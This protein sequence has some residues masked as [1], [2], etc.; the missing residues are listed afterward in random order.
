M[1]K[2]EL[3]CE[4]FARE[5]WEER[6]Y[7]FEKSPNMAKADFEN[8][9]KICVGWCDEIPEEDF[10]IT[11]TYMCKDRVVYVFVRERID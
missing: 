7:R 1:L 10:E 3:K 11:F 6:E 4:Q 9:V 5:V 8:M 2:M